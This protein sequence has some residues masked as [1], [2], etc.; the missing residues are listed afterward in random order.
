MSLLQIF[1]IYIYIYIY[2]TSC[3]KSLPA[4]ILR[5]LVSCVISKLS[6]LPAR[7]FDIMTRRGDCPTETRTMNSKALQGWRLYWAG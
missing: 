4:R 2:C 7:L 3:R 6:S 5:V 1:Y